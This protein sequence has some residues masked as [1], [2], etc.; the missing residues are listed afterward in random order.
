MYFS[1]VQIKPGPE[2]FN[3]IKRNRFEN[4]YVVHQLLWSLFPND[5]KKER[6]FLYRETS[7]N[8]LPGFF[9]VSEELPVANSAL[10]VDCK[11]YH[12]KIKSGDRLQFSLMA[13][14][15]KAKKVEGKKN[16]IKHDVWMD[17]K[18]TG[19]KNGK[20]G[21]E[22]IS[23][24]EYEAKKWLAERA[25][26]NG[27]CVDVNEIVVDGYYQHRFEH[28]KGGKEIKFRSINYDGIL[29][30]LT[31][32]LFIENALY[33]GIGSAKAFGC[34]LMLVRRIRT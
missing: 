23:Y 28:P 25:E 6:N 11:Q 3:I 10:T 24:C 17:A 31:P 33:K 12:P 20:T 5:G 27:S 32:E 30:V 9:V 26:K 4:G 2:M 15:V 14:P 13:N 34:G 7:E 18:K 1:R 19:E 16:S 8:G 22:L 21:A 29:T